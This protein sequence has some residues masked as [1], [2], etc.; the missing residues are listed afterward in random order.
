MSK[1]ASKKAIG[2]F[3]VGA[4]GLAV[5]AVIL[6]G[7]GKI[8]Q[9]SIQAV[10][11]FDGSVGGL[12][13]GAPVVFR[14][15]KV[16]SVTDI[17][18]R[19]DRKSQ[20][21]QIPVYIALLP[22]SVIKVHSQAGSG[23]PEEQMRLMIDKGLR[24]QLQLQS[25][26][27]GQLLVNLDFIPD[28]AARFVSEEG[29][30]KILEIPSVRTA[31]QEL[32]KSVERIP[33][34]E[35]IDKIRSSLEGIEKI[36][37]SPETPRIISSL[38]KGLDEGRTLVQEVTA[39][40]KPIA[41]SLDETLKEI[42]TLAKDTDAAIKPVSAKIEKIASDAQATLAAANV[43]LANLEAATGDDS[44]ILYRTSKVLR[45]LEAAVRSVRSLAD[46]LERQPESVVFGRKSLKE[47][48]K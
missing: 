47:T 48:D 19:Y 38:A 25:F 27:T 2:I 20:S 26:V 12:N 45:D 39:Q 42:Q 9:R 11:Y 28:K 1:Q 30:K 4:L 24:A 41:R 43:T 14:G 10:I 13:I 23:G 40:I 37:N 46:T 21:I 22:D 32:T 35:I 36:V 6:F 5:F 29:E 34:D 18:L 7:G 15:V 33:L 3:V 31:L 16:G 17:Q 8:F 44:E